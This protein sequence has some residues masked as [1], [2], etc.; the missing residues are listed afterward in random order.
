VTF[1]SFE[2]ASEDRHFAA[3]PLKKADGWAKVAGEAR[4]MGLRFQT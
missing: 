4:K 3:Q 1:N 2:P